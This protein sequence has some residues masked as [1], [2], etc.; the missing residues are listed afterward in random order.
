[1]KY[2]KEYIE[3]KKFKSGDYIIFNNSLN[4]KEKLKL[5][6][7]GYNMALKTNL[8]FKI[9]DILTNDIANIKNAFDNN[10]DWKFEID[11]RDPRIE[12]ISEDDALAIIDTKKYNL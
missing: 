9:I 1:M 4:F 6:L 3:Y 7:R 10:D 2:L 11:L 5:N 8:L 12:K